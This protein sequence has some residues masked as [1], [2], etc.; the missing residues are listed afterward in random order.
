M[1]TCAMHPCAK[2]VCAHV[3]TAIPAYTHMHTHAHGRLHTRAVAR[4]DDSTD[5]RHPHD[6]TDDRSISHAHSEGSVNPSCPRHVP[7][8]FTAC[9]RHVHGMSMACPRHVR[10]TTVVGDRGWSPSSV[11]K[12][13]IYRLHMPYPCSSACM[14]LC[15]CSFNEHMLQ[16]VFARLYAFSHN[17]LPRFHTLN[18]FL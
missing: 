1:R 8:M 10:T 13:R 12:C 15:A 6:H 3:S 11:A 14:G 17:H 4:A 9:P 2:S 7:G 16:C 18:T 5:D